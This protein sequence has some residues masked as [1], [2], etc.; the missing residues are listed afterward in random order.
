MSVWVYF[1]TNFLTFQVLIKCHSFSIVDLK[2]IYNIFFMTILFLLIEMAITGQLKEIYISR[3]STVK[4][5]PPDSSTK[6]DACY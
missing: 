4:K 5:M 6:T 1:C 2:L 3:K